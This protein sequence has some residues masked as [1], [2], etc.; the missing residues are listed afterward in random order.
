MPT[1]STATF[2]RA[3]ISQDGTRKWKGGRYGNGQMVLLADQDLLLVLSEEGE[4]ALVKATPDQFTEVARVPGAR[5]QDLEPP[6]AGRRRPAGA[7]RPRDGRVPAVPRAALREVQAGQRKARTVTTKR[8]F[9][10]GG[11]RRDGQRCRSRPVERSIDW[12]VDPNPTLLRPFRSSRILAFSSESSRAS[13]CRPI[14]S[15]ARHC[16]G[17]SAPFVGAAAPESGSGDISSDIDDRPCLRVLVRL[18]DDNQEGTA[19]HTLNTTRKPRGRLFLRS[20]DPGLA[21]SR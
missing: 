21:W 12:H 14:R 17:L 6:G 1:A 9:Y 11:R 15:F 4:L 3:S 13:F 10:S 2:S 18:H 5:G 7:Q 20:R 8:L 19:G 16:R